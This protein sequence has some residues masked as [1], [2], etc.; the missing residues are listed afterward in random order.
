MSI[1]GF[2]QTIQGLQIVKDTEAQLVYTFDWADWLPTGDS[3]STVDYVIT[4]RVNDPD[5]LVKVSS[6]IQGT[7]TY[8]ELKEGQ[9][10]KTYTVT[11]KVTT[12]DGLIDRRSFRVKIQDRS[13]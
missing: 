2:E 9:V 5:P 11:A 12:V 1:S 8:I 3:L 4:A 7:K 6:G 10:T 13:A